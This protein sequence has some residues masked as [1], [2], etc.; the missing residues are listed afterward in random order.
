MKKSKNKGITLIALVI[1]IIVILILA[2]IVG[3]ITLSNSTITNANEAKFAK[4]IGD[5]NEEFNLY[6]IEKYLET[7]WDYN[8][9]NLNAKNIEKQEGD[10]LP[11][12]EVIPS[13][14]DTYYLDRIEIVKGELKFS[15]FTEREF[16]I[17]N[18]IVKT[19]KNQSNEENGVINEYEQAKVNPPIIPSENNLL[20]TEK[21]KGICAITFS[22]TG[23]SKAVTNLKEPWY[24]YKEQTGTTENGGDSKWANIET[25]DGSQ[26][27]WIPRFA[28]KITK[29]AHIKDG[30]TETNNLQEGEAGTIEIKFLKDDTN[31]FWD[32]SKETIVT[33]PNK[34]TYTGTTQNEWYVHPAFMFNDK[35]LTGFWVAKYEASSKEENGNSVEKDNVLNTKTV[36]IKKGVSSWRY[37]DTNFMFGNCIFMGTEHNATYGFKK[38]THTHLMKNDEWGAV[39]Y[40][41]HSKYGRNGTKVSNN[42]DGVNFITGTGGVLASTTGNH[43]GVFDMAGGA[44]D[45]IAAILEGTKEDMGFLGEDVD[46]SEYFDIYGKYNLGIKG[47]A[48]Y[49]TSTKISNNSSWFGNLSW[50]IN[51][52]ESKMSR[53]GCAGDNRDDLIQGQGIFAFN[54]Y[55]SYW[56]HLNRVSFRPTITLNE[57]ENEN[58][59]NEGNHNHP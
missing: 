59:T 55:A 44:A 12:K 51:T 18:R 13:M 34:V 9:T 1:T 39:A 15:N 28:Y 8:K 48:T 27:V 14:K 17:I 3:A 36:Q 40:L 46:V 57:I 53:G 47:D 38:N 26:F 22:E 42:T 33:D 30:W 16:E 50:F 7:E 23:E 11:I 5:Y 52:G 2:G 4:N 45:G 56:H 6:L 43:Y 24:E 49:E 19:D 29:G 21:G 41:A 32:G 31:E 58:I 25:K 20:A 37:I 54:R 10:I 35:Q